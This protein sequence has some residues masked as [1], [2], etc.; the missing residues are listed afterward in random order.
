K[1]VLKD[2]MTEEAQKYFKDIPG[3]RI[4]P[5]G[6]LSVVEDVT[7]NDFIRCN[8]N[9][10]PRSFAYAAVEFKQGKYS[11][12]FHP[13]FVDRKVLLNYGTR[14]REDEINPNMPI[15][16]WDGKGTRLAVV[17]NEEGKNKFFVYDI[18]NRVKI[19]KQELPMFTQIQD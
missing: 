18:V 12:V 10:V 6:Q 19:N 15:L 13:N 3:R 16:A 7:K 14:T 17:Y 1:D 5:K 9:P 4:V 11:V 2:F 8:A